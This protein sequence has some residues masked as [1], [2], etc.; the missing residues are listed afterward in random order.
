MKIVVVSDNHGN[1]EVLNKILNDN[2]DAHY[3]F[4]LGDS[5]MDAND[6]F[7]FACVKGNIDYDYNLPYDKVVDVLNHSFFLCHGN[8]YSLEYN[9]LAR[10]GKMNDCDFVLF[11]HSH[12]FEDIVVDGVRLINPG[13]CSR[14]KD[15]FNPSYAIINIDDITDEISVE[16]VFLER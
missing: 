16:R 15:G 9:L 14:P 11:G 10:A 7:P 3:Y 4:H 6:L 13:S 8:S 2:Q 12:C 5:E 1:R